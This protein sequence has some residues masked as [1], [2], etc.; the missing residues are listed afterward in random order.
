MIGHPVKRQL[1]Q[2]IIVPFI[3]FIEYEIRLCA[4]KNGK[5]IDTR[6]ERKKK[7]PDVIESIRVGRTEI[8]GLPE[9]SACVKHSR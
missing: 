7:L 1:T 2:L 6:E 9:F 5:L 8:A 4:V 3:D